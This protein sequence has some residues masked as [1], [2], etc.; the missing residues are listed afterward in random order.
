MR[1][2]SFLTGPPIKLIATRKFSPLIVAVGDH[3]NY[4]ASDVPAILPYC[5]NV[6]YLEDGDV[7]VLERDARQYYG[8]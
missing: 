3:E 2:R 8:P 7:A 1:W 5:R 4:L 6:I